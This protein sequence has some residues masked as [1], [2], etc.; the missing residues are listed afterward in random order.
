MQAQW[1]RKTRSTRASCAQAGQRATRSRALPHIANDVSDR[2]SSRH[3]PSPRL[4][5]SFSPHRTCRCTP[6]KPSDCAR[7]TQRSLRMR[8]STSSTASSTSVLV[9]H[10]DSRAD[11]GLHH[12]A[13]S[14]QTLPDA[15][16]SR[17]CCSLFKRM[18]SHTIVH[19]R[20][21]NMFRST[22]VERSSLR[23]G[24]RCAPQLC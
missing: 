23:I 15:S 14:Q 20:S 8:C 18:A 24:S 10:N 16:T 7:N 21:S 9:L 17:Q 3:S 2:D 19:E 5:P 11:P 6:W 4:S 22:L 13:R 12:I 1:A